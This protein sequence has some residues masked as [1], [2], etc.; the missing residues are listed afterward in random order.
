MPRTGQGHGDASPRAR[1]QTGL[2]ILW[3]PRVEPL[4]WGG[5]TLGSGSTMATKESTAAAFNARAL[6]QLLNPEKLYRV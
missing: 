1:N 4:H 6:A 3:H 2:Q 5:N